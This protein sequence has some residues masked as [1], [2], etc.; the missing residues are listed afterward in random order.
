MLV[1]TYS[2]GISGAGSL[3]VLALILNTPLALTTMLAVVP[4]I[5]IIVIGFSYWTRSVGQKATEHRATKAGA[6]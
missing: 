2:L 5:G 3:A 6:L 4:V 1:D